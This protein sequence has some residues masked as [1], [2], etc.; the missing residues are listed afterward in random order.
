MEGNDR[1]SCLVPW[2]SFE[3]VANRFALIGLALV[4]KAAVHGLGREVVL[5]QVSERVRCL[6][7]FVGHMNEKSR[8]NFRGDS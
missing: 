5:E 8:V 1:V 4:A 7:F 2:Q 3:T 6:R